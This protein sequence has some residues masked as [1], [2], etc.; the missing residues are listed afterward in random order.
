MST[1]HQ[2]ELKRMYDQLTDDDV[3][4]ENRRKHQRKLRAEQREKDTG[5]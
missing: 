3:I 2:E 4:A 1:F 5:L